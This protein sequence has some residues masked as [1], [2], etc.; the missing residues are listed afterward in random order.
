MSEATLTDSQQSGAQQTGNIDGAAERSVRFGEAGAA[1]A[2]RIGANPDNGKLTYKV[3]GVGVGSVATRI[4]AGKHQFTVDEPAALAGDDTAASPVEYALG[5]VI[6]CQV[7]VYRLY[8]EQLGIQVD[9]ITIHAEGDLDVRGLFGIDEAVRPGFSDIRLA[10]NI[11]GP[12]TQERYDELA[13]TVEARCPV[14]DLFSNA[15]PFSTV[16]TKI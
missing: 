9:D 4:S 3:A 10:V 11:T 14:Q 15:T 12:E 5:A 6:S 13:R 8:A 7:V 16:I 2:Q 1:W